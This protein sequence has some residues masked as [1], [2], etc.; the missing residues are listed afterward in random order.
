MGEH[1]IG[2]GD[3]YETPG[4]A[5]FHGQQCCQYAL[6]CALGATEQIANLQIANHRSTGFICRL[7][8]H[9]GIADVVQVMPGLLRKRPV[10][11]IARNRA[12]DE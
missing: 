2:H 12:H 5:H 9:A 7:C 10:F 8:Q 1:R 3:I 4:P 6:H 11:A